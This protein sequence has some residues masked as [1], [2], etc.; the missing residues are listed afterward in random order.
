LRRLLA[1]TA[2]VAFLATAAFPQ[3]MSLA[4][5]GGAGWAGGGDLAG[6]LSGLMDYYSDAYTG[7]SGRHAFASLG[8]TLKGEL[9]IHLGPRWA[10]G[11]EAGYERHGRESLVSYGFGALT[12][13]ETLAPVL[14]A[15]PVAGVAHLFLPA[16][17]IKIDIQAGAGGYLT[18]LDWRSSY[19]LSV[20]GY[21]GI[22]DLSFAASRIGFGV[23][24]GAALEWPVSPSLTLILGVGGRYARISGYEGD[25]TETGSGELWAFS[26]TGRGRLYAYDWTDGGST[27]RQIAIQS[28]LP[29]GSAVSNAREAVIDL[30]GWTATAGIRI[31]LF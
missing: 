27:Y 8:W 11:L 4:L 12:A 21:E 18:R 6:G 16:G 3:R 28:G 22:D 29:E 20:L 24:A 5:R 30:T 23:Q 31:R 1:V 26:E 15:I 14:E 13:S 19:A 2:A 10:L 7:L 25:W 9:L 17:K